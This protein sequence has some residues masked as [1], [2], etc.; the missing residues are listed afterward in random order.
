MSYQT[1]SATSPS[2]LLDTVR[3]FAIANGWS[4]NYW[5]DDPQT[6]GTADKWLSLQSPGGS[7]FNL[8]AID[9][10]GSIHLCGATGYTNNANRDLQPGQAGNYNTTNGLNGPYAAYY[11]FGSSTYIHVVV[12]IVTNRFAHFAIGVL[13]KAGIYTG[14]EYAVNTYWRYGD[15]NYQHQPDSSYNTAPWDSRAYSP[16]SQWYRMDADGAVNNWY[17]TYDSA[18]AE[19]YPLG[20]MRGNALTARLIN[21]SPNFLTAQS[22]LVPSI[23]VGPRPAGGACVY[24]SVKDVRPVNIE[25]LTPKQ[26]LYIGTDEWMIF[27]IIRKGWTTQYE[28]CSGNYGIAYRKVM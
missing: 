27:P 28:P 11:M 16:R 8:L 6:A 13:E 14:G 5:G 15:T 18:S 24:G 26:I 7:Y 20:F 19:S 22:I 2:N 1:G 10:T 3:L 21:R 23:I 17:E 4:V 9:G 12:E 25:N